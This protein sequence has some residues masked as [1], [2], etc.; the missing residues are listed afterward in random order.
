MAIQLR[1]I[2]LVAG[3]LESTLDSLTH[4]LGLERCFVDPAVATFGLE[5][6][7]MPVG[8][9]FLEVVAPTQPGTAAGR[10]LE[11]RGGDGGYMVICQA[12]SK[13][14]QAAVRQRALE[15]GVRVAFEADRDRWNICQLHPGDMRASFFEIDWDQ[16]NDFEGNWHPA[17]GTAWQKHVRRDVTVDYRAVELQDPDPV[18]LAE[19]WSAVAGLPVTRTG[20]T[21][22]MELN[23]AQLR[24]VSDEDGRGSGL[25]G[26]ELAVRDRAGIL[27][28]ARERGCYVGEQRVDIC[29]TRFYLEDAAPA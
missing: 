27:E 24:F 11:R 16:H 5:N 15:E 23:N 18:S 4:I 17:G 13:A 29:G 12:G 8:H 19:R 25:G 14:E 6:T 7:L 9:N 21:L 22:I 10:Y 1:Q 28:R 26:I 2:C 3:T 20:S